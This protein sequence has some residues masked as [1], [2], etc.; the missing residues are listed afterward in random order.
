MNFRK[1]VGSERPSLG[2]ELELQLVD[3][4]NLALAGAAEKVLTGVP[5]ELEGSVKPE[6]H[7]CC[8]EVISGVCRD[9]AEVEQDLGSKV[10]AVARIAAEHG[11]LLGWGGTHP[12]S[13]WRDQPIFPTP[14]YRELVDEY[15]ET[16]TRQLTF[17]LHVHVGVP[18]G[19][20]AVCACNRIAEHLPALLAL[21]ANSP[22][23]CGRATGLH[24]QRVEVMGSSPTG[25]LPPRL[26]GWGDYVRL[27]ERLISGGLIRTPKELYWDVR[28]SPEHGTVEVR[29]CDMPPDLPSVL[30][31]AALIQC[32]VVE[33]ARRGGPPGLD[34]CGMMIVRQ[35]RWRAARH[36]LDAEIVDPRTGRGLPAREVIQRHV[37]RLRPIAGDLGCS[38]Q[39]DRAWAMA[40]G[41]GGAGQQLAVF[42]RTG[43]LEA[44]VRHM[45]CGAA[46][47]L[48]EGGN[49]GGDGSLARIGPW[50]GVTSS[51]RFPV[52]FN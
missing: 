20:A 44:V 27:V 18:G 43:D 26:D 8:V 19:G 16:L 37:S 45:T 1:F 47:I 14:R 35:N 46:S 7:D 29:M 49:A 36:G 9:V 48:P 24:S 21:S 51:P 31:L 10:A 38:R 15:R 22:F 28:P 39:L 3:A 32:L 6:F 41:A 30:G 13:H 23:W 33:L 2:V 17:G 11:L 52:S 50:P 25:G 12:F 34:E 42:E 40:G 4:R 5:A